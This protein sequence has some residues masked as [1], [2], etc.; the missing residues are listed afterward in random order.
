MKEL[1]ALS[2][3]SIPSLKFSE[4]VSLLET[5]RGVEDFR[6][7]KPIDLVSRFR[8]I[9]RNTIWDPSILLESAEKIATVMMKR[10]IQFLTPLDSSY[11]PQLKEIYDPPFL[12]FYRGILPSWNETFLAIV[13]TRQPTTEGRKAAYALAK[14]AS[15]LGMVI[16]SGLAR[17]IDGEAHKGAVDSGGKTIAVL[18]H[19]PDS[20]YP[21]SNRKLGERV[22]QEGGMFLSE[23]PPG[24]APLPYHFPARNRMISGLSRGV[25]VVEAPLGSGA[26]ITS[27]YAL[28]QG[29]DLFVHQVGMESAQGGGTKQLGEEGAP[30]VGTC[31]DI[32]N[33]WGMRGDQNLETD[34]QLARVHNTATNLSPGQWLAEQLREELERKR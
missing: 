31:R 29:R 18:G 15:S 26:L 21:M 20:V 13:G 33:Y 25:V 11:P 10:G 30:V 12:L 32:L 17:G 23:Y 4:R 7:L 19:G 16:V 28:E 8:R 3:G 22:L 34:S 2:I 1:L 14:E 6:A 27:D 24:T 9:P 5:V